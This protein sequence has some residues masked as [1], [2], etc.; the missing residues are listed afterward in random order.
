MTTISEAL[1]TAREAAG[2]TQTEAAARVEA[3]QGEWSAWE[4]RG[5]AVGTLEMVADRFGWRAEYLPVS[6]WK[7]GPGD[8]TDGN[9]PRSS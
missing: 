8:S 4:R 5:L 1:R 2:L 6:G 9:A 3:S 7:I